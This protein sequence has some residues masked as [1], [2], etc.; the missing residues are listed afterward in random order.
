MDL[1]RVLI[2]NSV[3]MSSFD[4]AEFRVISAEFRVTTCGIP[5]HYMRNSVS[6]LVNMSSF[7]SVEF[8]V[9]TCGIPRHYLR[10]SVSLH[11][12]FCVTTCGIPCHYLRNS[13]S[14]LVNMSS[15]D[16]AEFRVI[17]AEFRVTTCGIPRHYLR[18]S[19]N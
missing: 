7:D 2:F 8:H 18:N 6:L 3:N 12:E 15:F 11:A 17:S 9:T 14:L 13:V 19:A 5:R 1:C 16:P 10:N 4:P